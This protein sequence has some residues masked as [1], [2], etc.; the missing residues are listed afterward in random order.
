MKLSWS[1]HS[2]P[3]QIVPASRLYPTTATASAVEALSS[4]SLF[5]DKTIENANDTV[6]N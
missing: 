2:T 4:T 6:L 3:K 1:S 5:S